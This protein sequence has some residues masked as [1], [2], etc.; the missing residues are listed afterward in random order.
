MWFFDQVVGGL[1]HGANAGQA[2]QVAHAISTRVST[3]SLGTPK[4]FQ[5]RT[6]HVNLIQ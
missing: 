5:V 2:H 6:T 1:A 4:K 3:P